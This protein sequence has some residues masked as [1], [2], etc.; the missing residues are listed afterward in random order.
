MESP[1]WTPI[2]SKFSIEQI[3]TQLSAWSRISSSSYSF[4]PAIERSIKI[5]DTGDAAKPRS[6]TLR[7]VSSSSARPVPAPPKM[8]DG[9]TMRGYPISPAKC[10]ASSSVCANADS[11]TFKPISVIAALK[12]SRFSAVWMASMLAPIISTP[13]SSRTP[14]SCNSTARFRPVCPPS[15]GSRAS[16][17]SLSM[18]RRSVS[19]SSG[20][21]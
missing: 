4:Q 7:K 8:K 1:V 14:A 6:A 3:T 12:R 11:G 15:V 13:N 9:R 18:I 19:T 21:T 10:M 5:S 2:G 16:G 17:R 20:S